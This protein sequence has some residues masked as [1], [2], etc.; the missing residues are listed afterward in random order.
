MCGS[1]E[2][3]GIRVVIYSR[4]YSACVFKVKTGLCRGFASVT[5]ARV[6]EFSHVSEA[7]LELTDAFQGDWA[8]AK[9]SP[10]IIGT[11]MAV[12]SQ[13]SPHEHSE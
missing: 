11:P 13:G 3:R 2:M 5:V 9:W 4:E 1:S 7:G 10:R 6:G 8:F 12:A